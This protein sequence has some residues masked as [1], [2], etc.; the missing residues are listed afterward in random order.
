MKKIVFFYN[1]PITSITIHNT[2]KMPQL[3]IEFLVLLLSIEDNSIEKIIEVISTNELHSKQ[4]DHNKYKI[5]Q[6]DHWWNQNV[7]Y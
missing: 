5:V 6:R 1:N 2:C 4:W 3:V 7:I